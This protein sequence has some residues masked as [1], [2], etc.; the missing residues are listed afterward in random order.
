[1]VREWTALD[2]LCQASRVVWGQEALPDGVGAEEPLLP[3][4]SLRSS[5]QKTRAAVAGCPEVR[6]WAPALATQGLMGE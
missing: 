3:L 4:S 5:E 1:M 6:E 2:L